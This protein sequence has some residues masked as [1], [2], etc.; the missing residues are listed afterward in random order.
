MV[1]DCRHCQWLLPPRKLGE[2]NGTR[3]TERHSNEP[4]IK[5]DSSFRDCLSR[6]RGFAG[7]RRSVNERSWRQP[8]ESDKLAKLPVGSFSHPEYDSPSK[9][10]FPYFLHFQMTCKRESAVLGE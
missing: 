7:F 2:S 8:Y 9:G 3:I 6:I 4:Q 1:S 10:P 5:A